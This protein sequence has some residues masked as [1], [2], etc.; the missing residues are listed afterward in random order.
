MK[1]EDKN[2]PFHGSVSLRGRLFT[3]V[4]K[5]DKM[6]KT[7]TVEWERR[8]FV[9]KYE[10][11]AKSFSRVKAHNPPCINAKAGEKVRVKETRP[12]SKTKHFVVVE[13]VGRTAPLLK[14]EKKEKPEVQASKKDSA[15]DSSK[16]AQSTKTPK[17]TKK[18]AKK[19]A[20]KSNAAKPAKKNAGKGGEE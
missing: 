1:C 8:R 15:K 7:V 19:S 10:R 14:E 5:S 17:T 12:L 3:G 20:K 18:T 9:K 16:N 11:Y 4:V 2:C 6:A 13:V